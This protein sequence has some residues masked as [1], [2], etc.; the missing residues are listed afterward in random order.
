MQGLFVKN[1]A[2]FANKLKSERKKLGLTQ[3]QV[4]EICGITV[5]M[6]GNYERALNV[7]SVEI[8]FLLKDAG[9]DVGYLFSVEAATST[10]KQPENERDKLAQDEQELLANY[11]QTTDSGKFV[12][13]SVARTQEKKAAE[14]NQDERYF[15]T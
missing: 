4:A 13:L 14:D 9:F 10:L 7:P 8:I 1:I 3:M 12:I 6:W 5:R 2:C 15:G 11:R